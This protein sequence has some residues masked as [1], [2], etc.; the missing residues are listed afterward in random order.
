MIASG[1]Q[2]DLNDRIEEIRRLRPQ[3]R[4]GQILA[5]VGMLGE[6]STGRSLRD[7][8]DGELAEAFERFAT[9]LK[10]SRNL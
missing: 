2:I 7:L 5:T 6:D 1:T 3:L 4:I 10:N 9:D 8:D